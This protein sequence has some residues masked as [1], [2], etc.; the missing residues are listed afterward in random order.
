MLDICR[1]LWTFLHQET[2]DTNY[3]YKFMYKLRAHQ[4]NCTVVSAFKWYTR[5][6]IDIN[7][8]ERKS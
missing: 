2:K 6:D 7:V 8:H 3:L 5:R 4:V 1:V